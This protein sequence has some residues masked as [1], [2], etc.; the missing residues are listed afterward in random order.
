MRWDE[1][2]L[3]AEEVT[4]RDKLGHDT[5]EEAECGTCIVRRA[6]VK[7]ERDE[8]EGNRHKSIT[9]VFMTPTP[10]DEFRGVTSIKVWQRK[11]KIDHV[12][13]LE[14]GHSM[15]TCFFPKL[16]AEDESKADS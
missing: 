14:N 3:Y 15:L 1:A 7:A 12:A 13:S 4:G 5:V 10:A 2:T 11:F 8:T 16:G 6:P 9:R